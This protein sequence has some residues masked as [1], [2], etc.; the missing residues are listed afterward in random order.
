[1]HLRA[2]KKFYSLD[3][4]H[5]PN[6]EAVVEIVKWDTEQYQGTDFK[7]GAKVEKE[8]HMLHFRGWPIPLK[9]S[10]RILTNIEM[11]TQCV[12]MDQLI[13]KK[14]KLVVVQEERFGK[15][16]MVVNVHPF[17]V[18]ANVPSQAYISPFSNQLPPAQPGYQG[19]NFAAPPPAQ[20]PPAQKDTRPVGVKVGG[21]ILDGI[22]GKGQSLDAVL[23]FAKT[24][25]YELWQAINGK[26][27]EDFPVWTVLSIAQ[28]LKALSLPSELV[29]S[30]EPA[31]DAPAPAPVEDIDVPF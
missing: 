14:I 6:G 28:A 24:N 30:A 21:K 5:L 15:P 13:G 18:P 22:V 16:E 3:P 9:L 12:T 11:A 4:F 23:R 29:G 31:Q 20:L 1:M 26:A 10:N 19:V 2:L 27:V 25:D 8:R 17:M 7:T